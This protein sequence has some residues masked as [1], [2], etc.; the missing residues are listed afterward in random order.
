MKGLTQYLN[1]FGQIQ[2]NE[3]EDKKAHHV[4]EINRYLND[5]SS[6]LNKV[7]EK[8]EQQNK[9]NLNCITLRS[10]YSDDLNEFMR[11]NNMKNK[12]KTNK[13]KLIDLNFERSRTFTP[14]LERNKN[15]S[16]YE[17]KTIIDS[18][19]FMDMHTTKFE[20][21][22]VTKS[23]TKSV[24]VKEVRYVTTQNNNLLHEEIGSNQQ[25]MSKSQ[26]GTGF[27][28]GVGIK[29][30]IVLDD[31]NLDD[32]MIPKENETYQINNN[33]IYS[34]NSVVNL[35]FENRLFQFKSLEDQKNTRLKN[36]KGVKL[37]TKK[38]LPDPKITISYLEKSNT[39][40][41]EVISKVRLSPTSNDI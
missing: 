41:V 35:T 33:K 25:R 30:V 1:Q 14:K 27:E 20:K 17:S 9:E 24:I 32:D 36:V 40:P 39:K 28:T 19:L 15:R 7:K 11:E 38:N 34:S 22:M 8:P 4:D 5:F 23:L 10:E 37:I 21:T 26:V 29:P 2:R 31:E 12:I 6:S 16:K 3:N 13:I 18:S